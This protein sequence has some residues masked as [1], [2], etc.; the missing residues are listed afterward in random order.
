[1]RCE[2]LAAS[3]VFLAASILPG[4]QNDSPAFSKPAPAQPAPSTY[5]FV[6]LDVNSPELIPS[7]PLEVFTGKCKKQDDSVEFEVIVDKTGEPR[8]IT[9]SRGLVTD[10][11]K[12]ALQIVASDRFMPGTHNGEP[13][14]VEI[15]VKVSLK[16]CVESVKDGSGHKTERF[17]LRSQPAQELAATVQPPEGSAPASNLQPPTNSDG[18]AAY[19]VGG[20]VTAPV[21]LNSVEAHYTNAARKAKIEGNCWISIIVDA[22]GMPQNAKVIRG[23]DP[24]L[25]QN[26]LDAVRKYRFK[27]AMK[28]GIPVPVMV[29]IQVAFKLF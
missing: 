13:A 24:G 6:G 20:G 9:Y 12:L 8:G 16:G 25:D 7:S 2:F 21:P 5:Y 23:L 15:S 19:R 27:P 14:A 3:A 28:D 1:M 18:P 4:Q 11:D 22:N 10:A 17:Q 29:T 26:A